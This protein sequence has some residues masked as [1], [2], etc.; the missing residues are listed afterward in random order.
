MQN[1]V[2]NFELRL[3]YFWYVTKNE[4]G[5]GRLFGVAM[6]IGENVAVNIGEKNAA[7]NLHLL[8]MNL[9]NFCKICG[10]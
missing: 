9:V 8:A 7:T 2:S 3:F 4:L 1:F 5:F 6:N 10:S